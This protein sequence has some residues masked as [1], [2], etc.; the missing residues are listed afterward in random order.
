MNAEIAQAHLNRQAVALTAQGSPN[1]MDAKRFS[2]AA[3]L[4]MKSTP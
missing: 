4:R 1:S 3:R 2:V